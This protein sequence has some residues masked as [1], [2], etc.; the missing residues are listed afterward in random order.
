M[1]AR[2]LLYLDTTV[3]LDY[4][5]RERGN[6]NS[7]HLLDG[8]KQEDYLRGAISTFS[9]LE[10][11]DKKQEFT[12]L[13]GL[14]QRGHTLHELRGE[15]GKT[16]DLTRAECKRCYRDVYQTLASFGDKLTILT[17]TS[18]RVWVAAS[19]IC[20]NTAISA[21]DALHVAVA[22]SSDCDG[23]VTGDRFLHAQVTSVR[24]LS[25][26][27]VPLLCQKN[28]GRRT[29]D[30]SF[31]RMLVTVRARREKR[32]GPPHGLD[33]SPAREFLDLMSGLVGGKKNAAQTVKAYEA[34]LKR[35]AKG[36]RKA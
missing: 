21:P 16:R 6:A 1:K 10:A 14:V 3:L 9:V 20:E 11:V 35:S 36:P 5:E 34:F 22:Q 2:A 33:V 13:R 26:S 25:N 31:D 32:G 30:E 15:M 7:I 17:P 29:F 18:E 12:H 27:M 4:V 8:V 28:I 24:R 23:F 19:W